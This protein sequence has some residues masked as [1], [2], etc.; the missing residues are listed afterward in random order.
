MPVRVI[1]RNTGVGGS[2]VVPVATRKMALVGASRGKSTLMTAEGIS[3]STYAAQTATITGATEVRSVSRVSN[4]STGLTDVYRENIDFTVN[5]L[6]L[7]FTNA[8]ALPVPEAESL[9]LYSA[10]GGS[11]SAAAAVTVTVTAKDQQTG[12]TTASASLSY[13]LT[14]TTQKLTLNWNRVPFAGGYNVYVTITGTS[15]RVATVVGDS[16]TTLTLTGQGSTAASAPVTNTAKR[17]P[18]TG[19]TIYVDYYYPVYDYSRKEYTNVSDVQTDHGVGSDL[20]NAARLA[21]DNGASNIWIVAT[22]GTGASAFYAGLESL[23]TVDVQYVV[24]LNSSRTVEQYLKQHAEYCSGDYVGKERFGVAAI[25]TGSVLADLSTWGATF[26]GTKRMIPTVT[27]GVNYDAMLWQTTGG[28]WVDGPYAVPAHFFAAAFAGTICGLADSATPV[29]NS[30]VFGFMFPTSSST[31][32]VEAEVRDTIEG[33]G[34]TYVM[35]QAGNAV[36]YHGITN[37]TAT[38]EAQEISVVAAEDELRTSI[39][40]VLS[41]FKGKDRKI[42]PTRLIAIATRV[43]QV[44][45]DKVKAEIISS[46]GP[47]TVTQDADTPTK[48]WVRFAYGPVYSMNE[49]VFEYGF[50]VAP[51]AV[52]A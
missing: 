21:F 6:V 29:T 5:G 33:Y 18:N 44:L 39:R 24:P 47:V 16:T 35:E 20:S 10:T 34:I 13:T 37:N 14:A 2:T 52:A 26:S 49:I 32:W 11:W 3:I 9:S 48:L 36:V 4:T 41:G 25:A 7:N 38:V 43:R 8:Q 40:T 30:Q 23:K 28:T 42:T 1:G 51:L 22:T 45:S 19:Q 15:Y 46:F 50:S 12:E 31:I 27:N 17:R